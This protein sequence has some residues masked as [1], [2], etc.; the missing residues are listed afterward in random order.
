M[1]RAIENDP[2]PPAAD[3]GFH[4]VG[5]K[6]NRNAR[7]ERMRAPDQPAILAA[8]ASDTSKLA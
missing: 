1:R 2:A 7:H 3:M 6:K 5:V 8:S 4:P